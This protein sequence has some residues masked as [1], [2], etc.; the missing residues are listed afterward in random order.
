MQVGLSLD[1]LWILKPPLC[2]MA[3][4]VKELAKVPTGVMTENVRLGGKH[5]AS[6]LPS[7]GLACYI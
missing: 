3:R 6:I 1:T 2:V 4:L 5:T 7:I